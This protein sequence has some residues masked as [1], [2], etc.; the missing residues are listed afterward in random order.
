[1]KDVTCQESTGIIASL[2]LYY[3]TNYFI[4]SKYDAHK[5]YTTDSMV[6]LSIVYV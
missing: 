3:A 6:L 2:I 4:Y 5:Y 1:M